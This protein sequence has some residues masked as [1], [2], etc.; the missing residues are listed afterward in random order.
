MLCPCPWANV[1]VRSL[2]LVF[3]DVLLGSASVILYVRVDGV[4]VM[5]VRRGVAKLSSGELATGSLSD[6]ASE[7]SELYFMSLLGKP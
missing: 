2:I 5:F 4:R 3:S 6:S 7:S 1:F